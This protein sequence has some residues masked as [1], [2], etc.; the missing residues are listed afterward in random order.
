MA[1]F[2]GDDGSDGWCTAPLTADMIAR[3]DKAVSLDFT[4]REISA[5]DRA[6]QYYLALKS[7]LEG[8]DEARVLYERTA[9]SANSVLPK[10]Q[11]LFGFKHREGLC[12][13]MNKP[14]HKVVACSDVLERVNQRCFLVNGLQFILQEVEQDRRWC[15]V[16]HCLCEHELRC[17]LT[18]AATELR[19]KLWDDKMPM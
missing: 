13:I 18:P 9:I 7:M 8:K 4:L 14:M 6:N 1:A 5:A 17:E 16:P 19:R 3:V 12:L 15:Y 2:F 10:Y 11:Y